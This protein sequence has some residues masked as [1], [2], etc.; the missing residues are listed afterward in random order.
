MSQIE[1]LVWDDWAITQFW[2]TPELVERVLPYLD[3][4]STKMLAKAHKLTRLI[5]KRAFAWHKLVRR[6]MPENEKSELC[7][8]VFGLPL[9]LS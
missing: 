5:L 2:E 9:T 8:D 1:D 6:V 4:T 3:L 7:S